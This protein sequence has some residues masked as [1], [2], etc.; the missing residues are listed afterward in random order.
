MF[1]LAVAVGVQRGKMGVGHVIDPAK[2]GAEHLAVVHDAADRDAAEVD[3]V[4]AAFAPDQPGPRALAPRPVIGDGE[5]QR[6]FH[7]FRAGVGVE[8]MLDAL[9]RDIDQAVGKLERDGVAHLEGR[10]IVEF[11]RLMG[12]GFA[13][14]RA[15]MARVAAP[16]ARRPVQH[17]PPVGRGIVHVACRHEH[18]RRFL[19]LPV[20]GEGHPEGIEVVRGRFAVE[21]HDGLLQG[22]MP[23]PGRRGGMGFDRMVNSGL[24]RADPGRMGQRIAA[25]RPWQ[26]PGWQGQDRADDQAAHPHPAAQLRCDP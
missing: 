12:D 18:A 2:K 10:G 23:G 14:L 24:A 22:P 16:Q 26:G 25:A 3:A 17:L 15:A 1:R 19:E 4:I 8:H 6:R 11:R 13:D 7:A 21:R 5:F 9:G 20:R